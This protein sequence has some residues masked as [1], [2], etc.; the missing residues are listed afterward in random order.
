MLA[1]LT[2]TRFLA[3]RRED[4]ANGRYRGIT[5]VLLRGLT[6]F[7]SIIFILMGLAGL[8]PT[9]VHHQLLFNFFSVGSFHELVYIVTGL[10]GLSAST[11]TRYARVYFKAFGIL[12]A[13]VAIFGFA[14]NGNLGFVHVNLANSLFHLIIAVFFLY[15]GFTSTIAVATHFD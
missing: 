5:G 10:I 3:K 2:P 4:E 7:F 9:F 15:F 11:S 13:L 1:I 14:L 12:Y 8:I 6:L